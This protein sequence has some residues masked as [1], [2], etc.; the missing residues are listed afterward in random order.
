[1]IAVPTLEGTRVKQHRVHDARHFYAVR[2]VRAGTP[3]ELVARQAGACRRSDGRPDLRQVP[4]AQRWAGPLG[5]DRV[6]AGPPRPAAGTR[7][8]VRT[9]LSE[10]GTILGT[11]S[12]SPERKEV[13][14]SLGI[15]DFANSRGGTRTRDPGIMSA[16][17]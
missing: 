15:G 14:N 5:V 13:A 1:M 17:L 16:V 4:A 7:A 10:I 9:D 3:Y 12:A 2:A 8:A 11:I 6:R